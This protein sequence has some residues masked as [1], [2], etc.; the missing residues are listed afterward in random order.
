MNEEGVLCVPHNILHLLVRR[1]CHGIVC[2]AELCLEV[3]E[4]RHGDEC[5][6]PGL[7]FFRVEELPVL[8]VG[9]VVTFIVRNVNFSSLVEE[10]QPLYLVSHLT[11]IGEERLSGH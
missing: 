4:I 5:N 1:D 9:V 10:L 2:C 11:C 7:Y 6:T 3:Q 8:A